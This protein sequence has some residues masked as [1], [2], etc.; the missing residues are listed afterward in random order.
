[1]FKN[2]VEILVL[3]GAL[4]VSNDSEWG[5]PKFSQPKTK[6]KQVRFLSGFRNLNKQLKNKPYP[7]PIINEMLL[8]LQGFQ[9]AKSF[10]LNMGYYHI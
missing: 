4:E 6:S 8:K 7:M 1:M 10:D 3:M 5:D 2:K 9:Y